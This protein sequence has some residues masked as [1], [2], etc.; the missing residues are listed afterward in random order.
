MLLY[1][2]VR[3]DIVGAAERYP[4][5]LLITT[6]SA[7]RLSGL[8][9]GAI[10]TNLYTFPSHTPLLCVMVFNSIPH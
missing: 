2:I 10:V 9:E 1:P 8:P 6:S 7:S 4:S 5:I 3:Y